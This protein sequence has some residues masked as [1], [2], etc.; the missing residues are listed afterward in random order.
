MSLTLGTAP[1]GSNSGG[2]FNFDPPESVEYLERSPRWVRGR[3]GDETVVDSKNVRLLHESNRLPVWLF[4]QEDVRLDL[5][6]EEAVRRR[7]DLV[8]IDFDAL[9]EWLEEDEV[10]FGHPRDP[11]H[12]ID[13]RPTSRRLRIS[14][15]GEV[16]A[17][18]ERAVVL[19]ETGLPPRWYVPRE[20]VKAGLEPSDRRTVCAYK[21]HAE[22]FS[23]AGEDAIAWS[24]ADPEREVEPIRDRVAFYDERVDLEVDGERWERPETPFSRRR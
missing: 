14:I 24:Y 13:V 3:L 9:D 4:P 15:G 23:V 18:T 12:R 6:P 7:H 8:Q 21:G 16:V 5:V 17:D 1:F 2:S 10:Q 19:F 22:H 11:Y 20:D